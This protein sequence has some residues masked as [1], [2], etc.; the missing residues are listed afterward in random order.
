MKID[1]VLGALTGGGAERVLA[2]LANYFVQNGHSISIITF[3][4]GEGDAYELDS[5]ISR[6]KLHGGRIKNHKIRST[7][8]LYRHYKTKRNR[9]DV[10]ISFMTQNSLIALLVAKLYGIKIICSEHTNSL[11]FQTPVF[12]TYITRVF[13]YKFADQVTVLTAHDINFYRKKGIKVRVLPNPCTFKPI[14]TP[15]H[16][17]KKEIL[18][19][20]NVNRYKLKGFDSLIQL[21][22]PILKQ[23]KDWVLKIVGG[24]EKGMDVLKELIVANQMEDQ[25][26]LTGFRNDV[27]KLMHESDIFVLTSLYEGL[28][29]A[30]L[31]A[32]SQGMACIAYDCKTGP[33]DI[34]EHNKNGVLIKDQ[35]K[36]AMQKTL[37]KII[38]DHEYRDTLRHQAVKSLEK[39]SKENINRKWEELFKDL[40]L[41]I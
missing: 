12:I 26:I 31:E 3:N 32:M 19:V 30:L 24:G 7:N 36:V 38:H 11:K 25:I 9:P 22:T 23:N 17:R 27:N 21:A 4:S 39:Y 14:G 41:P 20:G 16:N 37:E 29:M 8:N 10:V 5:R 35:D 2:I 18:A 33:A 40:N 34:I 28:P 15:N 13:F 1:F 6:I